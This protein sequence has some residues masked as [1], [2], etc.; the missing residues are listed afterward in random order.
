M[1]KY[2]AMRLFGLLLL[3]VVGFVACGETTGP[4]G[5]SRSSGTSGRGTLSVRLVPVSAYET[6]CGY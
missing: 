4:T 5:P 3:F 2:P 6:D 1:R